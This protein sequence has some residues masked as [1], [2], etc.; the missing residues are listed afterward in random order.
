MKTWKKTFLLIWIGQFI[1][2]LTSSTVTYSAVFW[3]SIET[4]SPEVLA[5]AVLSGYLPQAVL[6]LFIGA[7]IDR[8]DRKTIMIVSDL[9]IAFCTFGLIMLFMSGNVVHNYLYVLFAFRSIG[10]AFYT[11][12]MQ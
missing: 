1:S 9:F 3:L 4:K 8:W 6:G 10:T 12:A 7:Y 5:Y 2:L 11:P